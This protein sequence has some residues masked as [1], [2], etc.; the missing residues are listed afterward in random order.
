MLNNPRGGSISFF[1]RP[2]CRAKRDVLK[3]RTKST[4]ETSSQSTS[5]QSQQVA[6]YHRERII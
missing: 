6:G 5:R 4:D 1:V 2:E 3:D